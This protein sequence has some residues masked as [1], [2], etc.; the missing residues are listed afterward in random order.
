MAAGPG[1]ARGMPGLLLVPG[2]YVAP[3]LAFALSLALVL[4]GRLRRLVQAPNV[5]AAAGALVGWTLRLGGTRPWRVVLTPATTPQHLLLVAT[6]ALGAGLLAT[7]VRN[8]WLAGAA[9]LL[10]GWWVAHSP[11]TGPQFW[12]A[13][14]AVVLLTVLLLRVGDV[15]RLAAAPLALAAGLIAAR[16][17]APWVDVGLVAAASVL[18]LLATDGTALLPLALLAAAVTITTDLGAG[19]LS[20]GGFG[21]VDLACLIAL[22]SPVAVAPA[23]RRMGGAGSGAPVAVAV[24]AGALAWAGRL[25]LI[26]R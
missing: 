22:A 7:R 6:V 12:R 19:R 18:P 25:A 21:P 9:A 1:D 14:L 5:A 23:A 17:T 26:H 16:A 3:L 11:A 2:A 13:W 10:A 4:S 8:R 15:R 24:L 20:H